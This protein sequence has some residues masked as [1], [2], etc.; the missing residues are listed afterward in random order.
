MKILIADDH[1]LF[2]QGMIYILGE[3]DQN[4]EIMEASTSIQAIQLAE[5]NQDLALILMDLRMPDMDGVDAMRVILNSVSTV[6]VVMLTASERLADMKQALN[7]GAMGYIAKSVRPA[8]MIS[9]IQLVLSGG[10]YI[11]PALVQYGGQTDLSGLTRSKLTPRQT[12]VLC[13]LVD[14]QANKEIAR[15]LKL[16]EA[17]VKAH[18]SSIFRVLNVS[19]RTQAALVAKKAGFGMASEN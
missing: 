7:A 8:I 6:P 10:L 5:E 2:R 15:Y 16:S 9:A 18:I 13:L 12:E 4:A 11:P 1:A 3:M 17:T 14:G 19:N